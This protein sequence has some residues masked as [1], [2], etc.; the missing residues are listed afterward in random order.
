MDII[1]A[2]YQLERLGNMPMPSATCTVIQPV[3]G[4]ARQCADPHSSPSKV[5]SWLLYSCNVAKDRRELRLGLG[6]GPCGEFA[7]ASVVAEGFVGINLG[8]MDA[9]SCHSNGNL[10]STVAEMTS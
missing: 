4:T 10:S 7:I 9:C 2:S 1:S 6:L 3:I 8:S 5:G